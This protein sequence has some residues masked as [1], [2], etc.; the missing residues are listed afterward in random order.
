MFGGRSD[1]YAMWFDVI[2]SI[3]C[4]ARCEWV[5]WVGK[6]TSKCF[7]GFKNSIVLHTSSGCCCCLFWIGVSRAL[8]H[9]YT[10]VKSTRVSIP[11]VYIFTHSMES[12]RRHCSTICHMKINHR[13]LFVRWQNKSRKKKQKRR[14]RIRNDSQLECCRSR[15]MWMESRK[16]NAS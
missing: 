1:Y 2:I 16:Q 13:A 15:F 4:C 5:W 9:S 10:H 11:L 3:D 12:T 14:K 7:Y 8:T 6:W